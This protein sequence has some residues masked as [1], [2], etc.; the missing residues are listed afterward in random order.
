MSTVDASARIERFS[1]AE[2]AAHWMSAASF[3]YAALSGLSLWT[4][5]LYWLT[6]VFGGGEAV[7]RWHPWA[8]VVFALVLGKMFLGWAKD[9]KLDA[10]DRRWLANAHRYAVHDHDGLPEPGRFNGG[11]KMLFWTQ[12]IAAA[13]LFASGLVLWFPE[14]AAATVSLRLAAVLL[15]PLAAIVSLAGIIVHVYMG[16][17]AV[18]GA[19]RGMVHGWVDR[20]WAESHHPKWARQPDKR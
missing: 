9:M 11:Q 14:A 5:A 19:F 20:E 7:R 15:H 2:R 6:A 3:L 12:T 4:P 16:T 17:A 13:V 8:G 10:S 18:P 1:F